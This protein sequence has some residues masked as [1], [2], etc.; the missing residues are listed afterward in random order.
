MF[1]KKLDDSDDKTGVILTTRDI[2]ARDLSFPRLSFVV[3]V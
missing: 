3:F 1:L 2:S